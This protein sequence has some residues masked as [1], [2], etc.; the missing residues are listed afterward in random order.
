MQVVELTSPYGDCE[1]SEN[2]TQ[3]GCLAECESNFV[4]SNCSC[5][6]I[7]MLGTAGRPLY[8]LHYVKLTSSF[9]GIVSVFD[10][11]YYPEYFAP[12]VQIVSVSFIR[13]APARICNAQQYWCVDR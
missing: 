6:D 11:C 1:Q 3:S 8:F 5:R 7:A 13:V 12:F 4:V 2:Y 10:E 9:R